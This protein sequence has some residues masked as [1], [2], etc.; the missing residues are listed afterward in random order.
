MTDVL[1]CV[2]RSADITGE[3]TLTE[4]GMALDGRYSGY[5]MSGHELSAL[6][7][8]VT[9]AGEAGGTVTV[10]TLGAA[11]AAEQLRYALSVG[12]TS[13]IHI[14]ADAGA[15]GAREVALEIASVVR[16]KEAEGTVFGLILV[17]NDSADAGNF[18]T[19]I[20]LAYALD[21]PVVTGVQRVELAGAA[22]R[23]MVDTA[24]GTETYEVALPAVGCVLEGGVQPRY[25]SL[26]G[27]MR[28]RKAPLE[29]R[30]PAL[31]PSG[32]GALGLR[33]PPAV[34]SEVKIL[35]EGASAAPQIVEVLR[36]TG[37]L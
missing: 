34:A 24:A 18:Q 16:A 14:T 25:P 5:T 17:G 29:S 21:R 2:K 9:V 10:L 3:V 12:A 35:G 30:S 7:I 22:A 28:A 27:R 19:G 15:Y 13:A 20:R 8:A 33:V 4:D 1:V 23:M 32:T 6:E 26:R 36:R 37:V 11:D 31:A